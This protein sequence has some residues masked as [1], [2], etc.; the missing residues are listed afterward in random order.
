MVT[1][2][3]IGVYFFIRVCFQLHIRETPASEFETR[4]RIIGLGLVGLPI[5]TIQYVFHV[6][7]YIPCSLCLPPMGIEFFV[8]WLSFILADCLYQLWILSGNIVNTVS[9]N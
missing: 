3:I 7:E 6:L 5:V 9:G 1:S 8:G 4:K 2:A